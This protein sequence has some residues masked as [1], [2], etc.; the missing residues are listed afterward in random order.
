MRQILPM[1]LGGVSLLFATSCF[2]ASTEVNVKKDGSGTLVTGYHFSP[3]TLAMLDQLGALGGLL[4]QAES[5]SGGPNLDLIR[6]M[7]KPDEES[8]RAD[9]ANY[10]EGVRYAKHESDQDA[11][12]WKGYTATYE[13]DDIR[14][15]RIDQNSM[16][17]KAKEFVDSTGKPLSEGKAG[18]ITFDLNGDTLVV[19]SSFVKESLEG[20]VDQDQVDQAKKMGMSPSEAIKMS[21]GMTRGMKIGYYI[22]AEGGIAETD[23]SHVSG[24][25]VTLSEADVSKVLLDPDLAP[26]VDRAAADPASVSSGDYLDLV[27]KLDGLVIETKEQVAIKL[28]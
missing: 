26:F 7:S 4:S 13:F 15:V 25:T 6:K 5:S 10:G 18:A 19:K 14:K 28:K 20:I 21:A 2:R 12:G 17:G 11:D 1:L 24:D 16:P 22:R 27:G 8:L 9:A 3:E 23:A